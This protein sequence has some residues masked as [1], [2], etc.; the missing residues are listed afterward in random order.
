MAPESSLQLQLVRPNMEPILLPQNYY[1]L[2]TCDGFTLNDTLFLTVPNKP[3]KC[4]LKVED[5]RTKP[6]YES[7]VEIIVDYAD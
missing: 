3:S 5:V 7:S 2:I 1:R 4:L 6:P